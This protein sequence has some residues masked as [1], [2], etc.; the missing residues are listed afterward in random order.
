MTDKRTEPELTLK[1]EE[2]IRGEATLFF[3]HELGNY[4]VSS[5]A[6]SFSKVRA[7]L[8]DFYT[9]MRKWTFLDQLEREV[10]Q[11]L[12]DHRIQSHG[13]KAKPE[14]PVEMANEKMLFYLR[15]EIDTLPLVAHQKYNTQSEERTKVFISY[16]HA[17]KDV[18]R[19]VQRH[20][21]PV[22]ASIDLWDDER[23]RAGQ[24]WKEEIRA[25]IKVTKVAILL[26][27]T[28]FL[29]SEFIAT[30]ELPPLLEAAEKE[31]AVILPIILKPCLFDQFD[32]LNQ[33]QALNPPTRPLSKMD[34]N[35]REELFVNMVRQ[36]KLILEGSSPTGFTHTPHHA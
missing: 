35:E 28:D 19:E 31:G 11:S 14:C 12:F 30:D 4:D 15:Q 9:P 27:S 17:D 2:I 26:I 8:E 5:V 6:R 18:L 24:K 23:I 32:E 22:K 3:E 36:T 13:G 16:S 1:D 34:L 33:F 10:G 21:K 25:A 20:F 7:R 29:G